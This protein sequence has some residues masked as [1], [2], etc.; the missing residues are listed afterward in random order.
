MK[1]EEKKLLKRFRE[2]SETDK[3]SLLKFAAFLQS[4]N[5]E[6]KTETISEPVLIA[7]KDGESV[8]GALKRLSASYPM[9]DKAIMLN[10]TSTLMTQ[11]IMQGRHK[12]EVILELETV[13]AE[14]YKK[15][16]SGI[17][18]Q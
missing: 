13:F 14:N 18:N 6:E 8:V 11:H 3:Q 4:D 5:S 17:Q 7:A 2:L 16:K 15:M 10:Q 9:L 1:A 12:V